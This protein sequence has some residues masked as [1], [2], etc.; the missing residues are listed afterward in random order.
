MWK[1]FQF[2]QADYITDLCLSDLVSVFAREKKTNYWT[3][4][5]YQNIVNSNGS[6][7]HIRFSIADYILILNI[8]QKLGG[9]S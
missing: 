3:L 9:S 5:N 4:F 8:K 1:Q 6:V 2:L 7:I